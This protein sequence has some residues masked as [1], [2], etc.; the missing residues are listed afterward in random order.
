[1]ATVIPAGEIFVGHSLPGIRTT[2]TDRL[3]APPALAD[4]LDG[5]AYAKYVSARRNHNAVAARLLCGVE[6]VNAAGP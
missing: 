4:R 1:M 5:C 2:L 3:C 6:S